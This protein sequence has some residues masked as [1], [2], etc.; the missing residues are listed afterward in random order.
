MKKN[1]IRLLLLGLILGLLFLGCKS[2]PP[3]EPAVEE[4]AV[5]EPV[6]EEPAAE[7][8][9]AEE[10]AATEEADL[11]ISRGTTAVDDR[12]YQSQGIS[13]VSFPDGMNTIGDYAFAFNNL[14]SIVIPDS[15]TNIG[16][17]AFYGNP[18]RDI[19][20]GA[21]VEL[22]ET[23]FVNGFVVYYFNDFYENNG[24]QKG[25]YL[26]SRGRWT[27]ETKD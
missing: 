16:R 20:I 22:G 2:T 11:T 9:A 17:L 7:E 3:A 21:N 8:P 23:A 24:R 4:P 13:N 26:Y 18:I 1:I 12:E 10:P 15:V 5:E 27:F 19:T 14:N 25:R 6:A